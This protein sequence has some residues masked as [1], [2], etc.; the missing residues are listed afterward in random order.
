[1]VFFR[2]FQSIVCLGLTILT[3]FAGLLLAQEKEPAVPPE[4]TAPIA[5]PNE[6]VHLGAARVSVEPQPLGCTAGCCT[7]APMSC[8]AG[9]ASGRT[10]KRGSKL[11]IA[12]TL[13]RAF[14]GGTA[15]RCAN[16]C[17]ATENG[18]DGCRYYRDGDATM[19]GGTVGGTVGSAVTGVDSRAGNSQCELNAS[20]SARRLFERTN[21]SCKI[22]PFGSLPEHARSSF[23]NLSEHARSSYGNLSEH[24][25]SSYGNLSEH[26]RSVWGSCRY[27]GHGCQGWCC[28]DCEQ[29]FARNRHNSEI[30]H[31]HVKGK[32][33][34]FIPMGNGGEGVPNVGWYHHVYAADPGYFDPRDGG[35]Y[36]AQ[37]YGV[38]ISVPLPPTVRHTM[39]YSA[40]M[41]ASRLTPISN[42]VQPR[43]GW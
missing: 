5:P 26:A 38:P 29:F 2:L 34:Y 9:E 28:C 15:G 4:I 40:G 32:L 35:V 39:N 23:G 43:R 1:M 11:G 16:G 17:C 7:T 10:S 27:C 25:K 13:G 18:N 31:A 12:R 22:G 30:F 33:A 19:N 24:A 41:P 42:V 20:D 36:A 6:P 8:T 3:L 21:D 14:R 37:G